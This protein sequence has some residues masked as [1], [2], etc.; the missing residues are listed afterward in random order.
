MRRPYGPSVVGDD[1]GRYIGDDQRPVSIERA[2]SEFHC[3]CGARMACITVTELGSA[4]NRYVPGQLLEP[5]LC[6]SCVTCGRK[7]DDLRCPD[8]ACLL[9]DVI[10]PLTGPPA[11]KATRANPE[12]AEAIV[13]DLAGHAPPT[14]PEMGDCMLCGAPMLTHAERQ[15]RGLADG[16]ELAPHLPECPWRRAREMFPGRPR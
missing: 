4:L 16:D 5:C 11:M 15:Q 12:G 7:L 8:I 3:A 2:I 10:Q 14:D 9:H 6:P 1:P 13:L